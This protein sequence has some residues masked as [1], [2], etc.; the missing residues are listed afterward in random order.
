ML[1]HRTLDFV[2]LVKFS[3]S[4]LISLS[5]WNR[6][7]LALYLWRQRASLV[8]CE[9]G[10]CQQICGLISVRMYCYSYLADFFLVKT[11]L[12][13]ILFLHDSSNGYFVYRWLSVSLFIDA[14]ICFS[15]YVS[16]MLL[17]YLCLISLF[18]SCIISSS[19]LLS[20]V[21]TVNIFSSP[22][23]CCCPRNVSNLQTVNVNWIIN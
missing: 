22:D 23:F 3:R 16:M 1:I 19:L 9:I 11:L 13:S 8:R 10:I 21:F 4:I 5:R 7:H 12:L 15:P 20:A 18:L 14:V 2:N 6:W 17:L